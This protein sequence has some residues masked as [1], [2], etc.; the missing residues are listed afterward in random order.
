MVRLESE[1]ARELISRAYGKKG[2]KEVDVWY[3]SLSTELP[4]KPLLYQIAVATNGDWK[5]LEKYLDPKFEVS[6]KKKRE[7]EKLE[8]IDFAKMQTM[9]QSPNEPDVIKFFQAVVRG[10]DLSVSPKLIK[11]A[12][13]D[14]TQMME[15]FSRSHE[16]RDAAYFAVIGYVGPHED[17][18]REAHI[19][20]NTFLREYN[21]ATNP[22]YRVAKAQIQIVRDINKIADPSNNIAGPNTIF[23][24]LELLRDII[25]LKLARTEALRGVDKILSEVYFRYSPLMQNVIEIFSNR[26]TQFTLGYPPDTTDFDLVLQY[27]K[28]DQKLYQEII[29]RMSL[30]PEDRM[31]V[32]NSK[33]KMEKPAFKSPEEKRPVILE[34]TPSQ[35]LYDA[36]VG[37]HEREFSPDTIARTRYFVNEDV[38]RY[39]ANISLLGEIFSKFKLG[40]R[41]RGASD[42]HLRNFFDDIMLGHLMNGRTP[43]QED[44]ERIYMQS[45]A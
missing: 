37:K 36:I 26:P 43:C 31:L 24:R 6:A 15:L 3:D 33:G 45:V 17:L 5:G 22:K 13:F 23:Q 20:L 28:N 9:A 10:E 38:K 11:A 27:V 19:D 34:Q 14:P 8:G 2:L 29:G 1:K 40:K 12:F 42:L 30:R 44:L 35:S 18:F 7:L 25:G 32:Q 41:L 4:N 21:S 16:L 39:G